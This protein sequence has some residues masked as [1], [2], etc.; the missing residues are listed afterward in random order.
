MTQQDRF[1]TRD[2]LIRWQSRGI[3]VGVWTVNDA[4]QMLEQLE[5]GVDYLTSDDPRTAAELADNLR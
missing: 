5:T 2:N 1:L 4:G 3:L